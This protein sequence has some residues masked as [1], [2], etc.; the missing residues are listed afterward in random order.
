LKGRKGL[1]LKAESFKSH[2][3]ICTGK[4]NH[5]HVAILHKR[6]I[7]IIAGATVSH[8]IS[9]VD[10]SWDPWDRQFAAYTFRTRRPSLQNYL[11][12]AT[13]LALHMLFCGKERKKEKEKQNTTKM[14][15]QM[16]ENTLK[17]KVLGE[18]NQALYAHMNNKR[19]MKKKKKGK[20]IYLCS[21]ILLL[22]LSPVPALWI[23]GVQMEG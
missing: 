7:K 12:P 6:L 15:L 9:S 5:L 23:R 8:A 4:N 17:A 10:S 1:I 21:F 18:M 14:K 3:L 22:G 20:G 13:N 19:K 16:G 2:W 11:L